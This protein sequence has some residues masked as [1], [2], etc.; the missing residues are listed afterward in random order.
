MDCTFTY[1]KVTVKALID[2]KSFHS[3]ISKALAKKMD[4]YISREYGSRYPAIRDLSIGVTNAGKKV[5]PSYLGKDTANFVVV[6]KPEYDLVLGNIWLMHI[7]YAVDRYQNPP[8]YINKPKEIEKQEREK[9]QYRYSDG[10]IIITKFFKH[11]KVM[12][13]LD[14][15]EYYDSEYTEIESECSSSEDESEDE[16]VTYNNNAS[17]LII[18]GMANTLNDF[19]ITF[20]NY[21]RQADS[22]QNIIFT[23]LSRELIQPSTEWWYSTDLTNLEQ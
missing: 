18:M 17:P 10:E 11:H 8:I 21:L 19:V 13:N 22:I 16:E 3:S 9:R 6:D 1:A 2:P 12:K 20:N 14:L 7:E 5:I 15:S 4:L 23:F